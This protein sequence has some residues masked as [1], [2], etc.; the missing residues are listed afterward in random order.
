M[1]IMCGSVVLAI[2]KKFTTHQL[3]LGYTSEI[4]IPKSSG[5]TAMLEN[6]NMD[7]MK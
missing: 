2:V 5:T 7:M 4:N 6:V 3:L 1:P